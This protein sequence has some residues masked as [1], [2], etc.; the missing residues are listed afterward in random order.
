MTSAPAD[1]APQ[2]KRDMNTLERGQ[3]RATGMMTGPEHLTYKE[4]LRAGT[5]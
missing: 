1:E 4:R 3:G 2:Y 5:I